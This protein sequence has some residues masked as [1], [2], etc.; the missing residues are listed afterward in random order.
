MDTLYL[1]L[2]DILEIDELKPE[3]ILQD[4]PEWDSLTILSV[5]AMV[6]SDYNVSLTAEELA[7]FTTA[8]DLE[9]HLK[10]SV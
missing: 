8:S 6:D 5:I 4:M 9:K 2:A 1:K 7:N 10:I 3:D